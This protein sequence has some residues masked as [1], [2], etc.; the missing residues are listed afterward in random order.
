MFVKDDGL[1]SEPLK[2]AC[3]GLSGAFVVPVNQKHSL[4]RF[5]AGW[6]YGGPSDI[7]G[8]GLRDLVAHRADDRVSPLV[9]TQ[10]V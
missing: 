3:N 6:T 7:G 2:I 8:V 9:R 10:R 1:Y 4:R 5:S